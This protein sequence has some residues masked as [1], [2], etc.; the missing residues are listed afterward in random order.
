MKFFGTIYNRVQTNFL[1]IYLTI[2]AIALF[3]NFY[4]SSYFNFALTE[5]LSYKVEDGWCPNSNGALGNHCFGDFQFPLTYVDSENPWKG[6]AN[7]YPPV[8][9]IFFKFFSLVSTNLS[10]SV[11]L[12]FYL[13]AMLSAL[14][15]PLFHIFYIQK[16]LNRKS[17]IALSIATLFFAPG[18]VVLDRGNNQLFT[19]PFLYLFIHYLLL[20]NK[21]Q[22]IICI[23]LLTLL[24]P[25]MAILLLVFFRRGQYKIFLR[26]LVITTFSLIL[27]FLIYFKSFPINVAYWINQSL[28]YQDYADRGVLFP[29]NIS[30][31]STVDIIL[32]V[33]NYS[34]LSISK[35]INQI[36]FVTVLVATVLTRDRKNVWQSLIVIL[37]LPLL[38][39]GTTFHYYFCILY[40]PFLFLLS[41]PY[42]LDGDSSLSQFV[43]LESESPVLTSGFSSL[44]FTML[45]FVAFIPWAIPWALFD[46]GLNGRGWEIIG[47][48]WLVSQIM[49]VL[50]FLTLIFQHTLKHS[51]K[52][53]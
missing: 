42:V 13:I 36:L 4:L 45:S 33:F 31:T 35:V 17:L 39:S 1:K 5:S 41:R 50:F 16:S 21:R 23:V 43:K 52:P 6:I 25:Q 19:L 29:V 8:S 24:K 53:V 44:I 49:L 12:T 11:S 26:G 30:F 15:F 18:M 22:A 3:L 27:S 51:R 34:D 47:V 38:F 40:V 46:E 20:D 28:E 48:N 2:L 7:V 9:L 32:K 10:N 14:F 37:V